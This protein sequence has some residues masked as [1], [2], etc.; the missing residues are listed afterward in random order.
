MKPYTLFPMLCL[1]SLVVCSRYGTVASAPDQFAIVPYPAMI[2]KKAGALNLTG[3][4]VIL[5]SPNDSVRKTA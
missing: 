4:L 2:E 5:A 3:E 1:L